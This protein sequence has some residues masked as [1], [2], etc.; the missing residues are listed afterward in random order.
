MRLVAVATVPN[1]NTMHLG[2]VRMDF[3]ECFALGA[4]SH[5]IITETEFELAPRKRVSSMTDLKSLSCLCNHLYLSGMIGLFGLIAV[6]TVSSYGHCSDWPVGRGDATSTATSE[7]KLPA[8]PEVLWEYKTESDKAGFEGTPIIYDGK[9]IVGDFDGTV[10]AIDLISGKKVW[11]VKKKDGFVT[12]AAANRGSVVI[13]DFSGMVYCLD[14]KNGDQLWVRD[15]EQQVASG[16]NF[17]GENVLLTSEGGTMFALDL[18]TGEP[19]W[20]Y[21][22]GDQLRSSPTIWKTFS[23]LGGCDGQL[24]KIDLLKG[25]KVG[26]GVPL[27]A[28]TLSTPSIIGRIA[29]V[30]T[31]PGVVL[32]IDVET[33]KILWTFSDSARASDIRSSPASL[34]TFESNQLSGITVVTT[35]NRRVLGLDLQNGKVL[36]E[37]VLKKRTDGSP[38]ICDGRAWVGSADGL[39]SA[40]DLKTGIETWSYQMSGQ[41]LASPAIADGR[42]VIAT[43]KG[44]VFCFGQN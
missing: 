5:R 14:T 44:S 17:F 32:A 41:I 19:K 18:K 9:V 35:R 8:K 39:L 11:S 30:P 43:E 22:T 33:Q 25:E 3:L 15:I 21:A 23:L 4:F 40:I 37:A 31:Q 10:H 38:I 1:W 29:I 13:G 12:S 6:S 28:P 27:Q 7:S 26:E 16:G 34:G 2:Q 20:N 36:W 42:L 24:H